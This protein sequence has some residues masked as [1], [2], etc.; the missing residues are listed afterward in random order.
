VA[1]TQWQP[2]GT[3]PP[4]PPYLWDDPLSGLVTGTSYEQEPLRIK[5]VDPV[6]PD[7]SEVRRAV[8]AVL[9][10]DELEVPPVP[11]PRRAT[12]PALQHTPGMVLPNPRAGWPRV[13]SARQIPGFRPRPPAAARAQLARGR[14]TSRGAGVATAVGALILVA[15]LVI[16]VFTIISSLAETIYNIFN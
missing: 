2:D 3:Q 10:D 14:S 5:V 8:D 4:P 15:V 1:E 7:L 6:E 16:I 12:S 13:P 9:S 11:G